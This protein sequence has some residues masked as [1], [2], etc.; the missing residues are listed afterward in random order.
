MT[1]HLLIVASLAVSITLVGAIEDDINNEELEKRAPGWGKRDAD[2]GSIG[3]MENV[4][5]ELP[6]YQTDFTESNIGLHKRR[7]GWGKR[8]YNLDL[9]STD[10]EKRAP[11]W[12]KRNIEYPDMDS[13]VDKRRPGWG[14]R[15]VDLDEFSLSKRRPGWGKRSDNNNL[16][17]NFINDIRL[18][19]IKL[20][21][22][23][24]ELPA[25]CPYRN[26]MEDKNE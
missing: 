6:G 20:I 1:P 16:C 13:K 17:Q 11:G 23:T 19:R 7:P 9:E 21:A 15:D 12:G 4:L 5:A 26:E 14:K 22:M 25:V 8:S 2:S 18:L 24:E 10:E 3:Y